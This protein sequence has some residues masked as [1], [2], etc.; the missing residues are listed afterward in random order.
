METWLLI[1]II[2]GCVVGFC[3]ILSIANFSL[4]KFM[5]VH[6]KYAQKS[7][8]ENLSVMDF[9]HNLN[10]SKFDG[11]I[12]I[13][14]TKEEYENYYIPSRKTIGLSRTTLQST[15]IAS[16]AII[17]HEMGHALQDFEGNKLKTLNFFRRLGA[18][19]GFF[20]L[21]TLI[22]GI[23]LYFVT[24]YTLT[25]LILL[26]SAGGIFLLAVLIKTITISIEKDASKKGIELLR[27]FLSE[28]ELKDCKKLLNAA[29][30]TYWGD[31]F[32]LLLSWTLLTRKTKMFR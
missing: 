3:L 21:P 4:E 16:F 18:F 9:I 2:V 13:S 23:I 24:I 12:S 14:Q 29:R 7:I 6:D 8:S 1:V 11:K 20:F 28:A 31:L 26:I 15:S 17:A 10:V 27:P 25:G 5:E 32:R 22:S 19:L 30:Q